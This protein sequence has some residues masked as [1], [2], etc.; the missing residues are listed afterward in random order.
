MAEVVSI[1]LSTVMWLVALVIT[2]AVVIGLVIIL[3]FKHKIIIRILTNKGTKF[4]KTHRFK[5]GYDKKRTPYIKMLGNKVIYPLPP[6][7]A[8]N[9]TKRGNYFVEAYKQEDSDEITYVKDTGDE[10]NV[11]KSLSTNERMFYIDQIKKAE[12]GKPRKFL[13]IITQFAP[14]LV[15][16][17]VMV[18]MFAFW[19]DLMLP[20]EK[21]GSD[22]VKT[23][24]NLR[25]TTEMQKEIISRYQVI[26]DASSGKTPPS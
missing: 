24:D 8:I 1:I 20:A 5:I 9:I 21:L 14:L 4:V 23:S 11:F 13:D 19:G 17:I 16:M 2:T 26:R 10:S 25:E 18:M 3:S 15:L 12:A 22:W 6:S 7:E